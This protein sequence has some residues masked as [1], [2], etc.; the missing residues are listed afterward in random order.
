MSHCDKDNGSMFNMG[1]FKPHFHPPSTAKSDSEG[2]DT[3]SDV[4]KEMDIFQRAEYQFL[5]P[6]KTFDDLTAEESAQLK[7]QYRFDYYKPGMYQGITGL[8]IMM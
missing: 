5:P 1:G 2:V 4:T 7:R 6:G 3:Y 8:G